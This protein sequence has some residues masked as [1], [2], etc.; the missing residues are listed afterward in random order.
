LKNFFRKN[1]DLMV[2]LVNWWIPWRWDDTEFRGP[3]LRAS[4]P[5]F[6]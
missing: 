2:E 5:L 4:V 3:P 6:I 1:N